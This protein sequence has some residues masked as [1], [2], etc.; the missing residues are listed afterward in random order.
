MKQ[1]NL[2]IDVDVQKII[3]LLESMSASHA[4]YAE[5]L[6]VKAKDAII[7]AARA[8][9]LSA[10]DFFSNESR[11][12][13]ACMP[14]PFAQLCRGFYEPNNAR[15]LSLDRYRA[16]AREV[17]AGLVA[18][19]PADLAAQRQSHYGET[20]LQCYLG[21][22]YQYDS[23][24]VDAK[25]V[26]G[27]LERG[28]LV[29]AVEYGPQG[30][31]SSLSKAVA[32]RRPEL[33]RMLL[34]AGAPAADDQKALDA[35]VRTDNAE[36][37][38]LLLAAGAHA[39]SQVFEMAAGE[40]S[41]ACLGLLARTEPFLASTYHGALVMAITERSWGCL[42][43]LLA[44]PDI[45]DDLF[46]C[47]GGEGFKVLALKIKWDHPDTQQR[48][49]DDVSSLIG[50]GLPPAALSGY[51]K[52]LYEVFPAVSKDRFFRRA[53]SGSTWCPN[54]PSTRQ[55]R[56]LVGHLL[57]ELEVPAAP[58]LLHAAIKAEAPAADLQLICEQAPAQVNQPDKSGTPPLLALLTQACDRES[59]VT[60]AQ[61]RALLEAGA[62]PNVSQA[63]GTDALTLA[64]RYCPEGMALLLEEYGAVDA[65]KPDPAGQD[66]A[67]LP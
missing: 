32:L 25:A 16:L 37:L 34:S 18:A 9:T 8:G 36:V 19:V 15:G 51:A 14:T 6:T 10:H 26:A 58:G 20:V 31:N 7:Q 49:M 22:D 45:P 54:R 55:R 57:K 4:G 13:K 1:Y 63:N 41:A 33:V 3:D 5:A 21:M 24:W 60:E 64:K 23:A 11:D 47:Q 40:D 59:K 17:L 67:R 27:L 12:G 61:A 56:A 48:A 2:S 62:D 38:G 50:A 65:A 46:F 44:R 52:G 39:D 29:L 30:T 43:D 66:A 53:V 35:A 28:G 42:P